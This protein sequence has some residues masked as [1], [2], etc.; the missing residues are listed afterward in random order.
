M[1]SLSVAPAIQLRP[2]VA[3]V[4]MRV[5]YITSAHER[6]ATRARMYQRIVDVLHMETVQ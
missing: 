5:R 1:Q 2:T 6:Y 3:G 4:E